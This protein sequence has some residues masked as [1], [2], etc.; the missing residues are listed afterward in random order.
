MNKTPQD[1]IVTVVDTFAALI[2]KAPFFAGTPSVPVLTERKGDINATIAQA[3]AKLGMSV[4]VI[5]P[6]ANNLITENDRLKLRLRL[7]AE[8]SEI[9]LINQTAC[10]AAGIPY[11]PALAAATQIMRAVSRQPNGL[12]GAQQHRP[13]INEFDLDPAEPFRLV[14][15]RKCVTYHITAY[16]T[17]VL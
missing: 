7:I 13:R 3:L 9:V 11:R 17:V 6:D 1:R 4:V 14:P 15:D 10:K 8:V 2:E 5:A 12:D 16:T